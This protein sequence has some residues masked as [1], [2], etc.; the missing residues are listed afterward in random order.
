[1][2]KDEEYFAFVR[3]AAANPIGRKVKLANLND[4]SDL[5]HISNPTRRD[6]FRIERYRAAIEMVEQMDPFQC[7]PSSTRSNLG[8]RSIS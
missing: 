7:I 8:T 1:M 6:L 2:R 4:N 5:A 3:R